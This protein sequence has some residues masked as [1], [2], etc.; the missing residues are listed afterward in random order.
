MAVEEKKPQFGD[1]KVA[2]CKITG[3]FVEMVFEGGD[4]SP[5]N[6]HPGWLCLH[7]DGEG[8]EEAVGRT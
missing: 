5:G 2:T 8:R 3:E 6:G 7:S 1:R 4:P